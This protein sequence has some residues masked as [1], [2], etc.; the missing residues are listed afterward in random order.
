[1][2]RPEARIMDLSEDERPIGIQI[3]GHEPEIMAAA[4]KMAEDRGAD[5]VDINMGCPVPKITKGKDGCALMREPELAKEIVTTVKAAIKI[6]L[7]VKF[8]LGWDDDTR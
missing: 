4:A 5:F 2:R 1:M 6:P 7:T 8:R 3:F